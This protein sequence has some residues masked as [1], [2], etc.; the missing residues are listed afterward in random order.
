MG[1]GTVGQF[2]VHLH[3]GIYIPSTIGE[4]S[5]NPYWILQMLEEHRTFYFYE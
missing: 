4:I 2:D 3:V 5:V 1:T